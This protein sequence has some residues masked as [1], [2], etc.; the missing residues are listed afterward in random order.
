MRISP[1]DALIADCT[2]NGTAGR[3][4]GFQKAMDSF[5][6]MV[7]IAIAAV[8]IYFLI[9]P[10]AVLMTREVFHWLVFIGVIPAAMA[11][12]LPLQ[13]TNT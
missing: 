5:G 11:P 13:H 6:A 9:G 7:G 3:G 2:T 1:R 4:F 12:P 8:L 10:D